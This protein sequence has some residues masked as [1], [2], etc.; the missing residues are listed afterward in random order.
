MPKVTYKGG[1]VYYAALQQNLNHYNPGNP[2]FIDVAV[3]PY[4]SNNFQT[5]QSIPDFWAHLQRHQQNFSVP[6]P[7]PNINCPHCVM[8]IRYHP[9]KPTEPIFHNCADIKIEQQAATTPNTFAVIFGGSSELPRDGASNIYTLDS[10]GGLSLTAEQGTDFDYFFTEGLADCSPELCVGIVKQA[11]SSP[12]D[13]VAAL[14]VASW[15]P[16]SKPPKTPIRLMN[17]TGKFEEQVNA[18]SYSAQTKQWIVT[19][20]HRLYKGYPKSYDFIFT[21]RTLDPASGMLSDPLAQSGKAGF[22]VNFMWMSEVVNDQ[23]AILVGNENSLYTLCAVIHVVNIKTGKWVTHNQNV[24]QFALGEL[25]W[26]GKSMWAMSPRRL[27]GPY[28]KKG[29]YEDSKPLPLDERFFLVSVDA[30]DGGV[31]AVSASTM[32]SEYELFYG[33]GV[34]GQQ[35]TKGMYTYELMYKRY[36]NGVYLNQFTHMGKLQ[37]SYV[38]PTLNRQTQFHTPIIIADPNM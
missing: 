29:C 23:V 2:G 22:Y 15:A 27:S 26:N 8:R 10:V 17:S 5:L 33:G 31:T 32:A 12:E 19:T 4:G 28:P 7:M 3:A 25:H 18:I 1:R 36:D 34:K 16:G 6:I 13:D 24:T 9:N 30:M 35:N 38:V 20:R 14:W 11:L 21:V 37:Q